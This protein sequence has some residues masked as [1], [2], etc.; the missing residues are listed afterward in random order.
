MTHRGEI[1]VTA[2]IVTH[3]SLAPVVAFYPYAQ[4]TGFAHV[5]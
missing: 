3:S 5:D 4:A 1:G 2:L